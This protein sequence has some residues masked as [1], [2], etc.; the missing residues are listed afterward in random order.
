MTSPLTILIQKFISLP[1]SPPLKIHT[2]AALLCQLFIQ[3]LAL[4]MLLILLQAYD[5]IIPPPITLPCPLT[6]S[7]PPPRNPMINLLLVQKYPLT[8]ILA[9]TLTTILHLAY[10][11]ELLLPVQL[12]PLLF[13]LFPLQIIIVQLACPLTLKMKTGIIPLWVSFGPILRRDSSPARPP[14]MKITGVAMLPLALRCHKHRC[15]QGRLAFRVRIAG[16]CLQ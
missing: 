15:L 14:N 13:P 3:S 1:S 6:L 2:T 11:T 16:H 10:Q 7:L 12:I 5:I 9:S 4:D 8:S